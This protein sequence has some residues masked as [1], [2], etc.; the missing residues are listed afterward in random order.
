MTDETRALRN[1]LASWEKKAKMAEEMV[2]HLRAALAIEEEGQ[3]PAPQVL[4]ASE[5]GPLPAGNG[6]QPPR[7]APPSSLEP[8]KRRAPAKPFGPK[9]PK[10]AAEYILELLNGGKSLSLRE[11]QDAL[12]EQGRNYSNQAVTNT[13]KKMAKANVIRKRQAPAQHPARHL[14]RKAEGTTEDPRRLPP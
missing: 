10:T 3:T 6:D 7:G 8:S 2:I 12:A 1:L 13:L 14:Y 11:I 4:Q 5:P 9:Y